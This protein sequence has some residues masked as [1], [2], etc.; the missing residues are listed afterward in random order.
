[1]GNEQLADEQLTFGFENKID[2]TPDSPEI[3]FDQTGITEPSAENIKAITNEIKERY[4][5]TKIFRIVVPYIGIFFIKAHPVYMQSSKSKYKN[6]LN[7]LFVKMVK[8]V[9]LYL[10]IKYTLKNIIDIL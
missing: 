2:I 9:N 3:K 6:R 4:K 7:L 1:M 5:N 8:P 10:L